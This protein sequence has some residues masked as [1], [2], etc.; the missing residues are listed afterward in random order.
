MNQPNDIIKPINFNFS[1]DDKLFLNY[2]KLGTLQDQI[3]NNNPF[4]P[5]LIDIA[6]ERCYLSTV[7]KN[8][9]QR[10]QMSNVIT[11]SPT[12]QTTPQNYFY[13]K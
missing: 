7:I 11:N 1:Q 4:D 10:I 9:G 2:I 6:K 3:S 8:F 5:R 13:K 12:P